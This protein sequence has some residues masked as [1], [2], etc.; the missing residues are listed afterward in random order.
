MDSMSDFR[1]E[2]IHS[3]RRIPPMRPTLHSIVR[4]R[5]LALKNSLSHSRTWPALGG[6]GLRFFV[7][8]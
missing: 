7:A 5:A 1:S 8:S 3:V 4:G 2:V 6:M